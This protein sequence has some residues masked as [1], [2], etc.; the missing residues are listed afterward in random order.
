MRNVFVL[1]GLAL[2]MGA[3]TVGAAG[4]WEQFHGSDGNTG[5]VAIGPDLRVYSTP[6]FTSTESVGG[7]GMGF[8]AGASGPVV[9][10]G[11]I[12]CYTE[13]GAVTAFRE[14]T[15]LKIWE[16]AIKASSFGS[17]SSPSASNGKVYM[18]S[19][20]TVYC[21]DGKD[22]AI[23]WEYELTTMD[24]H[25]ETYG[26]VV[27][28]AV[29]IAEDIGLCY[30]HTYGSFGGGTRLHAIRIADGTQAWTQDMTGQGQGHVAYNPALKYVYTTVGVEGGWA[31]GRG[32]IMALD[33]VTGDIKWTSADSFTEL[34]FG[35]ITFD[36]PHNWV[37]AAG[38]SFYDYSGLLV[39]DATTGA[40]VSYSGDY[41][42][43]SGD[44]TPTVDENGI[45]YVCGAEFQDG[46]FA[47]AFNGHTGD[48][49]WQTADPY[50]G[51]WN[52]SVA[53]A[54]DNGN[55]ESVVYCTGGGW[56]IFEEAFA[57]LDAA[58]GD[59][60]AT[61]PMFAGNVA[62]ANGNLYFVNSDSKLVA[63]GPQLR[64]VEV[65]CGPYGSVSPA[66]GAS[67]VDGGNLT[68][69]F[70]GDVADVLT[71]GVSVGAVASFTFENVTTDHTLSV[72]FNP[73][74]FTFDDVVFWVGTGTNRAVM[75]LDFDAV[76]D[77][78]GLS[79]SLAWG[80]RWD[81]TI[82]Q[83]EAF[84]MVAAADERLHWAISEP[85][86]YGSSPIAFGYDINGNG[87][88]F[89]FDT[90]TASDPADAVASASVLWNYYWATTWLTDDVYENHG[91]GFTYC[92]FGMTSMEV[93]NG[94]FFAA[95]FIPWGDE[96]G[97]W[98][99]YSDIPN[100]PVAAE[101]PV[102]TVTV[103]CGNY[104]SVNPA[105]NQTV[106]YGGSVMFTFGGDVKGIFVDDVFIGA[107]SSHTLENITAD[108]LLRVEFYNFTGAPSPFAAAVVEPLTWGPYHG[109][110]MLWGKPEL[111]LGQ[112][113]VGDADD[114][115]Y[116][117]NRTLR[118]IHMAW[119]AWY[120]GSPNTDYIG[121]LYGAVP[122]SELVGNGVGLKQGAQV[123]VAF[124]QAVTNDA[125]NPFGIDFI[126]HGNSFFVGNGG[127]AYANTDMEDYTLTGGLFAEP[128]TV[129]VAQY[130]EGP[131][132][133]YTTTFA[134]D[135]FPTQPFAWDRTTHT[136]ITDQTLDWQK[137]VDPTLARDD[138]AGL[139][140]ADA[141]DL[142]DGSAGGTGFDLAE[143]GFEWIRYVKLTDPNNVQG[144][145]T[146]L[147]KVAPYTGGYALTVVGGGL[148]ISGG[149]YASGTLLT[150]NAT[151]ATGCVFTGWS[152][153]P[154]GAIVNGATVT[155]TMNRDVTLEAA[156]AVDARLLDYQDWL[157]HHEII[158]TDTC[159][160]AWVAG[161]H[162]HDPDAHFA[163]DIRHDGERP[164]LTWDPHLG[165]A[166]V[167][168]LEGKTNLDDS[169]WTVLDQA[170]FHTLTPAPRFF[171]VGVRLPEEN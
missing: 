77:A 159:Y 149:T 88:T 123:V 66:R 150:V 10:D 93:P 80:V 91:E 31:D 17:W 133:T 73:P 4:E 142:Y 11:R 71:N 51:T 64:T 111:L 131:W 100:Y 55:G 101:P 97:D 147:A 155:F 165:D 69:T 146:G 154:P 161:I 34:N 171:R 107:A 113:N 1:A 7:G 143:S 18:G 137:P 122:A 109:N 74:P 96:F 92:D 158:H 53:Y 38:Y 54:Q 25:G 130:P 52:V 144:E 27:N 104:G 145:I 72:T 57:M 19:G 13:S 152:Q 68:F 35:G 63:F 43:P 153:L 157:D 30:M 102:Y 168:I 79:N 116:S 120:K 85:G 163:I 56:N 110:T 121:G 33:A 39:C 106:A 86:D 50:W 169:N 82:T 6:R 119:P 44:Y 134:D 141:I 76:G 90:N 118:A 60:L 14:S 164:H 170:T 40:T 166:R 5:R 59:V 117:A 89:D 98:V 94:T 23:I 9:A 167:Y 45:I 83:E 114:R 132:Y 65:D 28:A 81:G 12:Y 21:L 61:V 78:A 108:H 135:M 58:T 16:T 2:C 151:P 156:F 24:G 125:R 20:D 136:W 112:P 41:L 160:A 3:M 46:P 62:L 162:P 95:K 115:D 67:V 140:V 70:D 148:D 103:S 22:G 29:T 49:V 127:F 36:A 26:A 48:L 124:E 87:G 105:Q 32:G 15:G 37:V 139:S 129:S 99:W 138:F 84:G 75:L 42:A 47:F 126:V 8:G 128:V